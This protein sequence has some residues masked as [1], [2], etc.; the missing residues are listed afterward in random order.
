M[1]DDDAGAA[2]E[3]AGLL[4]TGLD[5]HGVNAIELAGELDHLILIGRIDQFLVEDLLP[6]TI[7]DHDQHIL[8][9]LKVWLVKHHPAIVLAFTTILGHCDVSIRQL[10]RD[11]LREPTAE[12]VRVRIQEKHATE[13]QSECI[14]LLKAVVPTS[15]ECCVAVHS[16]ILIVPIR[17]DNQCPASIFEEMLVSQL[18]VLDNQGNHGVTRHVLLDRQSEHDCTVDVRQIPLARKRDYGRFGFGVLYAIDFE[19]M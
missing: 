16:A 6:L 11:H 7:G 1:G 12:N 17:H 10:R 15:Q 2:V 4:L 14:Y 3:V 8:E 13:R 5:A 9:H 19:H 18:H